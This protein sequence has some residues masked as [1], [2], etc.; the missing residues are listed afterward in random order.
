MKLR[1][2]MENIW[3]FTGTDNVNVYFLDLDAKIIIDCGN[4]HDHQELQKLIATVVDPAAVEKVIFTHL[5]HDHI[6]NFDLFSHAEFYASAA[7]IDSFVQ[8]PEGTILHEEVMNRFKAA[9]KLHP[10]KDMHGL[11]MVLTPG[12]T[13]GSMCLFYGKGGVLFTGDT[14]FDEFGCVGR[15]D[16]PSSL[17]QEMAASQEKIKKIHYKILCPGHDY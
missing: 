9:V 11:K 17:P 2:V 1:K 14:K 16:L 6:G 4:R 7:E 5:H 8:D 15:T 10:M 12:H 3:K 13:K